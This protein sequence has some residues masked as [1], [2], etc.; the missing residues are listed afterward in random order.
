[1]SV[2]VRDSSLTRYLYDVIDGDVTK[3]PLSTR[4]VLERMDY[5]QAALRRLPQNVSLTYLLNALGNLADAEIQKYPHYSED[6]YN[7]SWGTHVAMVKHEYDARPLP[8]PAQSI[9]EQITNVASTVGNVVTTAGGILGSGVV[10]VA[11]A[12]GPS[13]DPFKPDETDIKVKQEAE[14]SADDEGEEGE[15]G[16]VVNIDVI[17]VPDSPISATSAAAAS[18][19][20]PPAAL[21]AP[22]TTGQ[23][24]S[25]RKIQFAMEYCLRGQMDSVRHPEFLSKVS[26]FFVT[27]FPGINITAVDIAMDGKMFLTNMYNILREKGY[28][29]DVTFDE[30]IQRVA[31]SVLVGCILGHQH[32]GDEPSQHPYIVSS[33]SAK[34]NFTNYKPG[35]QQMKTD[36]LATTIWACFANNKQPAGY[37]ND[38]IF[39]L[40]HS[41]WEKVKNQRPQLYDA[42][43]YDAARKKAKIFGSTFTPDTTLTWADLLNSTLEKREYPRYLASTSRTL[44]LLAGLLVLG[45]PQDESLRFLRALAYFPQLK[46]TGQ[47]AERSFGYAQYLDSIKNEARQSSDAWNPQ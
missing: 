11:R 4:D 9:G 10:A 22:T 34:K 19:P 29:N 15:E 5:L 43:Y 27:A 18:M 14:A 33:I 36:A 32:A 30:R 13:T 20:S 42:S 1:M 35:N 37:V 25:F 3:S 40:A 46:Y 8:P 2:K 7:T 23:L 16:E 38:P 47:H 21:T 24:K 44:L 12:L 17:P 6:F 26:Q 45:T 41:A 31:L 28:V 39:N